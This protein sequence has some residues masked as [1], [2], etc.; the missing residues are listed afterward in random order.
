MQLGG[1]YWRLSK[2]LRQYVDPQLDDVEG[3]RHAA[4]VRRSHGV[5]RP[6]EEV[7]NGLLDEAIRLRQQVAHVEAWR[8][9]GEQ[10]INQLAGRGALFSLGEWWA[11]RPW[12]K[13]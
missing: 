10:I 11:D 5:V 3:V 4:Y 6:L 9:S 12:R 8:D 2:V 1:V 13:R 7:C